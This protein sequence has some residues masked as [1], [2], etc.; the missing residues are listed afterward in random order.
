MGEDHVDCNDLMAFQDALQKMRLVDDKILFELNVALPSNSFSANVNK[1]ERCRAIHDQLLK[2]R[3][4]RMKLIERCIKEN[5]DKVS[6]L[7]NSDESSIGDVRLAQNAL[8]MVKSEM[9][10]EQIVNERSEKAV[11]DR[12]RTFL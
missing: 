6:R 10:V 7:R 8:R 1:A 5:Q 11:H 4:N 9:D 2:I 12:C 3:A